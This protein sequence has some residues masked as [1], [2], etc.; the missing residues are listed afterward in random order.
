MEQNVVQ[1]SV[2][3][4]Q[5]FLKMENV[6]NAHRTPEHKIQINFVLV[7]NVQVAMYFRKMEL[8]NRDFDYLQ[9]VI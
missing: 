7:N 3:D 6:A 4:N 5:F 8:V 2:M 9:N 1:M